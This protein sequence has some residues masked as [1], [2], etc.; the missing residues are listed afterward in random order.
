MQHYPF[1]RMQYLCVLLNHHSACGGGAYCGTSSPHPP[2]HHQICHL[3]ATLQ[4]IDKVQHHNIGSS[5]IGKRLIIQTVQINK[6]SNP[7]TLRARLL[8][9]QAARDTR[10][11]MSNINNH[12]MCTSQFLTQK[13]TSL[14][15]ILL[16]QY[17]K[18]L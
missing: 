4:C 8:D 15:L 6:L 14:I 7:I 3:P 10:V 11:S 12:H 16:S 2:P 18:V 9:K 1:F 17:R 5:L 13:A